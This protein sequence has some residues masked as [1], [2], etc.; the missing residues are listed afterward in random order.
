MRTTPKPPEIALQTLEGSALPPD[1]SPRKPQLWPHLGSLSGSLVPKLQLPVAVLVGASITALTTFALVR[2]VQHE[3]ANAQVSSDPKRWMDTARNQAYDACYYGCDDCG[4]TNW[5][6]NACKMTARANVTGVIC[7][8]NVMWNWVERYPI[9]CLQAVGE[10]YRADSL[11]KLKQTYR[12]QLA[13]IILTTLAGI[14]GAVLTYKIWSYTRARYQARSRSRTSRPLYEINAHV[15]NPPPYSPPR[16]RGGGRSAG[17]L[18]LLTTA[19]ASAIG[20]GRAWACTGYDPKADQYFINANKTLSGVVHGWFSDCYNYKC[21]CVTKCTNSGSGSNGGSSKSCSTT[22]AKCIATSR[23]P[24]DYVNATL[25]HITSC[26]F[27][28][29]GGVDVD[30]NVRVANP[31]IERNWWVMISVNKFNVTDVTDPSV[32]CLHDFPNK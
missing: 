27:E 13:V 14:I 4:D 17:R 8:G 30:V 16:M 3:I 7:D 23:T 26:G 9:E 20:R 15:S 31:L 12:N 19:F 5:A 32:F 24:I 28:L 1:A 11:R 21:N 2:H 22:C 6:Y 25:G 29:V 10:F 18:A